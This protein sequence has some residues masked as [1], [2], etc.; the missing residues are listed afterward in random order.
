MQCVLSSIIV[1]ALKGM[2]L[3]FKDLKKAWLV[4]KLNAFVWLAT[5][6]STVVL[7]IEYGLMVGFALSVL[8][9][10][11]RSS[12]ADVSRLRVRS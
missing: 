7:D 1:V 10:L 4:S 9:L 6:I 3:Q 12:K 8:T 5:F 11:W 2:F